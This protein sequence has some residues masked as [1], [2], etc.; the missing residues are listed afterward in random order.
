MSK[1]DSAILFHDKLASSWSDSYKK[2]SFNLRFNFLS[3]ILSRYVLPGSTWADV[4]C[5]AGNL[6]AFICSLMPDK[7]FCI[8]GSSSMLDAAKTSIPLKYA[9]NI[10]YLHLDFDHSADVDLPSSCSGILLSSVI[11]Y[12]ESPSSLL[13]F[14]SRNL[15]PD[16]VLVITVPTKFSPIRLA[17]RTINNLFGAIGLSFFDYIKYSKFEMSPPFCRSFFSSHDLEVLQILPF[18]PILSPFLVKLMPPSLYC[19][20][21]SRRADSK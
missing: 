21:C 15:Q 4:G 1:K 7:V 11:E 12:S 9:S 10:S 8:D 3:S 16:G 19:Y 18:D 2:S 20:V 5:G 14:V 17:Q 6:S 13:S